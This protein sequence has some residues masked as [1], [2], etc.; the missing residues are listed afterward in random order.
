MSIPKNKLKFDIDNR[1]LQQSVKRRFTPDIS[2]EGESQP[3]LAEAAG[4]IEKPEKS[5][6]IGNIDILGIFKKSDDDNIDNIESIQ[7]IGGVEIITN[8][9]EIAGVEIAESFDS[10]DNIDVISS[11]DDYENNE[12][13]ESNESNES[14][15]NIDGLYDNN[16]NNENYESHVSFKNL[17]YAEEP[18]PIE[19]I[20]TKIENLQLQVQKI[21]SQ[22]EEFENKIKSLQI[23]LSESKEIKETGE[24]KDNERAAA[25]DA[26]VSDVTEG[27]PLEQLG[28]YFFKNTMETVVI[29]EA[30]TT[31]KHMSN[32][33]KCGKCFYDICAIALNA[34]PSH[35]VTTERGELL[36]KATTLLNIENLTKI[37]TEIFRAIDIV[38]NHPSH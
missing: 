24:L 21:E 4:F 8:I 7:N 19:S 36:Q 37:S 1:N 25:S 12:N 6:N 14:N 11:A 33:C 17:N 13:I 35:Y 10:I 5:G 2:T 16:D 28:S 20:E 22:F 32:I 30:A 23:S 9:N 29:E 27:R 18:E 34:I 31:V 26:D 38:R 3:S 15:D